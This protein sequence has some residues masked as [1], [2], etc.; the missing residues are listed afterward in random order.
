MKKNLD[1]R[2][3]EAGG[4]DDPQRKRLHVTEGPNSDDDDLVIAD[5]VKGVHLCRCKDFGS[6]K[7]LPKCSRDDVDEDVGGDSS[8]EVDGAPKVC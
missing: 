2:T 7:S 8:E 6:S 3:A 4:N 5:Y 1:K